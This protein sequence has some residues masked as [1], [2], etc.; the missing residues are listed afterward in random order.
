MPVIRLTFTDASERRLQELAASPVRAVEELGQ[1][2]KE[3]LVG[4]EGHLKLHLLTGGT[5]GEKRDGRLPLASRSGAAGLLGAVTHEQDGPLSGMYGT[6]D[7]PTSA[8]AQTILGEGET[9]IVPV[10]AAHLWIPIA[11]NLTRNGQTRMSPREA[12]EQKGPRG[13][14]LLSIFKS[15]N[16]NLVAFLR[17]ATGKSRT[18]KRGKNKGRQR[19][20]LLFVL[21]DQVTVKGTGALV[22]AWSEREGWNVQR[23]ERAVAAAVG[24]GA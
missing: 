2:V 10:N 20:K 6:A 19:G 7:G 14:R 9:T 16:G 8:Y 23:L 15:R 13:G 22:V 17:D 12:F 11:D 3:I 18:I 21:K 5:H 1:A 4:L 24:G